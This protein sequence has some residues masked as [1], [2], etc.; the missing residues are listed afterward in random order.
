MNSTTFRNNDGN[1]WN[2]SAAHSVK[3]SGK[4]MVK[5]R[6][7]RFAIVAMQPL[8]I[9]LPISD[10]ASCSNSRMS[11]SERW[12]LATARTSSRLFFSGKISRNPCRTAIRTLL[13]R[14]PI[15]SP[16]ALR[17]SRRPHKPAQALAQDRIPAWIK[18]TE[19]LSRTLALVTSFCKMPFLADRS[20]TKPTLK[21]RHY[22]NTFENVKNIFF[23]DCTCIN[24][25]KDNCCD[26]G[27]L[28]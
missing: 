22:G 5:R 18:R 7:S 28:R 26:G 16:L 12:P 27:G 2:K 19:R 14:S 8:R 20:L 3:I 25:I 24:N 15:S 23:C 6:C 4:E 10:R 1:F 11:S 9:T 13:S 21:T 17:A